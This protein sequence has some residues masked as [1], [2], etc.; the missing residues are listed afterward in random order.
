MLL[1]SAVERPAA[2]ELAVSL[3]EPLPRRVGPAIETSA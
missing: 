2:V 1:V 3:V